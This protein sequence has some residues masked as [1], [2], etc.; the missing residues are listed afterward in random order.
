MKNV[1]KYMSIISLSDVKYLKI[2]TIPQPVAYLSKRLDPTARGW[3]PCLRNLAAIAILIE[4]VLKLS[5]GDKLT[6][7][8]NSSFIWI[9]SFAYKISKQNKLCEW[10][11]L[12]EK[13]SCWKE[14]IL[15][16]F[17]MPQIIIR[18]LFLRLK[19][20]YLIEVLATPGKSKAPKF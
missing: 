13:F 14:N 12:A 8:T 4:N 19:A 15:H 1:L 20:L 6:I 2:Q 17:I 18:H 5:F 3:P 7:F 10:A 11:Y 16:N 9:N